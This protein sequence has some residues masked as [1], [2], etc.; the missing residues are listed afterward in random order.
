MDWFERLTGFREGGYSE[1]KARLRLEA[2]RLV[3]SVNGRS[4]Q[5]GEFEVVSLAVLRARAKAPYLTG[6]LNLSLVRGDVRRLHAAHENRNALFQVASQF[7][8]LEMIGPSVSPED[9]VTRYQNDPTQGPACAI[10]AGAATIFRNYF[11]PVGCDHGQSSDRQLDGL[12]DL[13]A[14][15]SALT[16]HPVNQL[17][18]MQN[19]YAMGI[20]S[21]IQAIGEA[22]G[23]CTEDQLDNLRGALRIGLQWDAGVTDAGAPADHWVSQAFCSALPV[24]YCSL[25]SVLWAPFA[26]LVLEAA[27]EATLHAGRLNLA[28]GRSATVFLTG[29]GGGAFGNDDAWIDAALGRALEQFRDTPLDVRLVSYRE[30]RP[31]FVALNE[32]FK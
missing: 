26:R 1:A 10:A 23:A 21:G 28:R 2:G 30:H 3:S 29:L 4:Y 11:A 32:A 5:V 22:L 18:R 16:G 7:N 19:G 31:G 9:G 27:Y 14:R 8:M 13:G 17:W 15:L 25:P 12:A 24:S 6:R 20:T